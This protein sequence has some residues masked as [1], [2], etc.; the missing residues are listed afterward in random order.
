VTSQASD[1][2]VIKQESLVFTF[3]KSSHQLFAHQIDLNKDVVLMGVLMLF[4]V[5]CAL[6]FQS[7]R[8]RNQCLP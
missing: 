8:A 1:G 7:H 4:L 6:F 5:A 3:S 2:T